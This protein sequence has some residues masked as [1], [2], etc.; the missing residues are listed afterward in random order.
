MNSKYCKIL[1]SLLIII[2]QLSFA[3]ILPINYPN[4]LEKIDQRN[5][6]DSILNYKKSLVE[7]FEQRFYTKEEARLKIAESVQRRIILR[8]KLI[9]INYE[10]NEELRKIFIL[11]RDQEDYM[12]LYSSL[13]DQVSKEDIAFSKQPTPLKEASIKYEKY[14]TS[15]GPQNNPIQFEDGDLL[16]TRGVSWFS[17][18]IANSSS[19]RNHFSHGVFITKDTNNKEG[20]VE[21]YLTS[22]GV[23][24]YSIKD[25]LKNENARI[26]VYR[27]RIPGLAKLASEYVQTHLANKD[28]KVGYDYS[29]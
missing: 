11:L 1:S 12:A 15:E 27:V 22:G 24:R 13:H 2:S 14:V 10:C 28:H 19:N 4:F 6:Q 25:A 7:N 20:T 9:G 17:S 16:I 8:N 5:C 21:S 23:D 18:I 26:Q 3:E 29:C